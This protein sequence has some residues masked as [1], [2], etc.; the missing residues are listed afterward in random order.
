MKKT[1][2][3][4]LF[5]L[6]ITAYFSA[7]IFAAPV[8]PVM[9]G[10]SVLTD[11]PYN[12]MPATTRIQSSVSGALPT[13][14][15]WGSA[16]T[17]TNGVGSFK[18]SLGATSIKFS[19]YGY[20]LGAQAIGLRSDVE[21]ASWVTGY[22]QV[23]ASTVPLFT[24]N[25]NDYISISAV[26]I[27]SFSDWSV[28]ARLQDQRYPNL[29]MNVTFAKGSPFIWNTFSSGTYANIRLGW[30]GGPS[31]NN[32]DGIII[33]QNGHWFAVFAPSGTVFTSG[34][35][36]YWL[37]VTFPAGAVDESGRYLV[38]AWLGSSSGASALT[39]E[40]AKEI[41]FLYRK[42]AYNML[43]NTNVSWAQNGDSS[44]TTTFDYSVTPLRTD[45]PGFVAGKTLFALYPHQ[46]RNL[47]PASAAVPLTSVPAAA[48]F[49]T[50]RGVMKMYEGN[51]FKTRYDFHG[52]LPFLTYEV[53]ETRR[54]TLN[55]LLASDKTFDPGNPPAAGSNIWRLDTYYRGKAVA[56]AANLIPI[57]HQH[58]D[59]VARN[60]MIA[61]LKQEL[62]LWYRAQSGRY[63]GYDAIWGGIIGYPFQTISDFGTQRY[64]DH[65]FHW[66]YF[67]YASAILA[68]YDSEFASSSGFKD[69]VDAL[70]RDYENPDKTSMAFPFLRNFDVYEGHSWSNGTVSNGKGDDGIDQESSSEAMNAWAAIYLWGIATNNPQWIDLGIYGYA[71]ETSAT[72]EYSFDIH[73]EIYPPEYTHRGGIIFDAS[74][75]WHVWWNAPDPQQIMGIWI[76]PI[77]PSMLYLGYDAAYAQWYYNRMLSEANQSPNMWKDIWLRFKSLFDAPGALLEFGNGSSIATEEG[78][79][80][81]ATY[82]F[83]NFFNA[84]GNVNTDYYA[85]DGTGVSI[86]FNIM[87]NNSGVYTFISYNN[88]DTLVKRVEFKSRN[89]GATAG[90]S[91]IPPK[92][93][94]TTSDFVDFKF[95][96]MSSDIYISTL[97]SPGK[98]TAFIAAST[99]TLNSPAPNI[100]MREIVAL[101][102]YNPD[103]K[104]IRTVYFFLSKTPAATSPGVVN[105][106][107]KYSPAVIIPP[108]MDES[109][110]RLAEVDIF[111]NVTVISG[112]PD[113]I[114]H[115]FSVDITNNG[116]NKN[117]MFVY[118]LA[119]PQAIRVF[120]YPNPYKPSKHGATGIRFTNL[121]AGAQISIYNIS[122]EKVFQASAASYGEYIWNVKN[123]FGT[124]TAS[125]VYI[126]YI[127]NNG[128]VVKGKLVIER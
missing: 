99:M 19:A 89:G 59:I 121:N 95:N 120:A 43:T 61:K 13:N 126:Y 25:V 102:I 76:L 12:Y 67:I 35:Y 36:N 94:A 96:N 100:T 105:L 117:Y 29:M 74:T 112:A 28:T 62:S 86:P 66:G 107:I 69:I 30:A 114:A 34:G 49:T 73:N 8:K 50:L 3:K 38:T 7:N 122:G 81:S 65:H 6:F 84:M 56:R 93:I 14:R 2:V 118:P 37:D 70:V 51:S 44:V 54:A 88:S 4:V 9:G 97:A 21:I 79:S 20:Q 92:T 60:T 42:Y 125:G 18:M 31:Y 123:M 17:G 22:L 115:A 101:P 16:Y 71:T 52:I 57:L 39:L 113:L 32:G 53:P 64:N 24:N 27:S 78:S 106:V 58:G 72:Q 41:F 87:K 1:F 10:S 108:G 85:V 82:H 63:F 90:I 55:N 127:K 128:K 104:Y 109:N 91:Y 45:D 119:S 5:V 26:Q 77:T 46:W 33:S 68:M 103:Y 83:I 40:Q 23:F 98:W 116:F 110:I 124:N 111:G 80:L 75:W 47:D 48:N 15:W 11:W